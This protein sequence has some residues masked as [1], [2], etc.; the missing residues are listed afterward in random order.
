M[1]FHRLLATLSLLLLPVCLWGCA[2]ESTPTTAGTPPASSQTEET[3]DETTSSGQADAKP[4]AATAKL[5]PEDV[6]LKTANW[7]EVLAEVKKHQGKVVVLDI[8][9]TSCQPCL[10]E[11][12]KLV[13]LSQNYPNQVVCLSLNTDYYG[14]SKKPP[15]FYE[16]TVRKVL[17]QLNAKFD[18]YLCTLPS[19]EFYEE[20][21]LASIP[22]VYVFGTDGEIAERFDNDEQKYGEEFTYADHVIPK[23]ESLLKPAE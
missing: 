22:A 20:I 5:A 13:N 23:I 19:D 15:E 8:W 7:E 12:P 3:D 2:G 9:S 17:S 14:S 6:K 4:D 18:N 11:F 16:E 21:D 1:P 10:R